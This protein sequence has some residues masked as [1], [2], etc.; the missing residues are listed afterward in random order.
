[1]NE[2]PTTPRK[3]RLRTPDRD[4]MFQRCDTID[5]LV[6]PE[7]RVRL[8]WD[9]AE[10]VDLSRLYDS[11]KSVEGSRGRAATDPRLYFALWLYATIDGVASARRLARLCKE[12]D[13]Y[14]WLCGGVSVNYHSLSDFRVDH[15]ELLEE[16]LTCSMASLMSENAIELERV[17]QDG[18]R[19]RASAGAASF[20]REPT[21]ESCLKQAKEHLEALEAEQERDPGAESRRHKAARERAAR[22]RQ[23]RLEAALAKMPEAK[24]RKKAKERDKARVS[25]TDPDSSVMRMADGGWRPAY[26]AQFATDTRYQLVLGVDVVTVGSDMGQLGPMLEQL[27]AGYERRPQQMLV[28]GGFVTLA[29]IDAAERT[30]T[31]IYAPVPEPK[32]DARPRYEPL[33]GDPTAVAAWRQRMGTAEAKEIYKERASTAELVNGQVRNRGLRQ[34]LVRGVEK[35]R[36]VLL[37]H[38]LANNL[39]SAHRHNLNWGACIA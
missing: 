1:M 7:H 15:V 18:M 30:G 31:V 23:Q 36:A 17:A 20:R 34:F 9:F 22:E 8:V 14:R 12:H 37:W 5:A 19:V 39:L 24:R 38:S 27:E 26:N 35:V 29:E 33:P 3:L 21:L 28:D 32:D 25:T 6:E 2:K 11:I 10:R 4:Q 13:A 16:L